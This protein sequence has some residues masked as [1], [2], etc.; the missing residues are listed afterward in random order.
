MRRKIIDP[1]LSILPT[2]DLHGVDRMYA[3]Y[4]TNEFIKENIKLGNKKILIIHG[5]GQGI[6]KKAVHESLKCN[7]EVESFYIDNINVGATVV[8]IR[9]T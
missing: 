1:F 7:K 2:L 4:K 5:I 8:N 9:I 6:V 3:K